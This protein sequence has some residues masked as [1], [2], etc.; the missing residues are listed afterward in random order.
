VIIGG[1]LDSWYSGTGATDNAAGCTV[2]MEVMRLLKTLGVQATQN[3]QNCLMGRR[4]TGLIGSYNYVKNHFGNPAT[5]ELKPISQEFRRI[6]T[7][8]MAPGE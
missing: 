2:M 5:K 7:S 6:I 4:R 8:T 3:D 1:H